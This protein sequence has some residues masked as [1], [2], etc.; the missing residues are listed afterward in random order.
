MKVSIAQTKPIKGNIEK[1]LENHLKF[2]EKATQKQADIIV[3]PELSLT[4]Y[5]PNLSRE[6]ATNKK[7]KRFEIFQEVSDTKKITICVGVPTKD[8]GNIFITMLIFRPDSEIIQYSKQHLYETETEFFTAGNN[9]IVLPFDEKNIV[10]PAICFETSV[11]EH[12]QNAHQKNANIYIA[13]VLNSVNGI[14]KDLNRISNIAKKYN[15]TAF[16]SNFSGQSGGYECAG[17][18]AIWNNTGEI[19]AQLGGNE[20]AILVYNTETGEIIKKNISY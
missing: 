5:E 3:F 19:I 10:A 15:M 1:N 9:P 17:K 8:K 12:A 13:S 16:M 20:E 18:S 14:D 4:G 11:E 2:I 7:D 6:L